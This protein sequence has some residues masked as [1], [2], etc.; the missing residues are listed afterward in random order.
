MALGFF[1]RW[2]ELRYARGAEGVK[3][4]TTVELLLKRGKTVKE[5]FFFFLIYVI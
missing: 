1:D 4:R 2:R 3:L 5:F